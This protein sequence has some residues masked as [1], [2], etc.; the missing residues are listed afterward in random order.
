LF[1]H[2]HLVAFIHNEFVAENGSRGHCDGHRREA[3]MIHPSG[4]TGKHR[5]FLFF[6]DG[7]TN[8]DFDFCSDSV[9]PCWTGKEF[10]DSGLQYSFVT[11]EDAA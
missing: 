1:C 9:L 10:I 2:C 7:S 4:E 6:K 5:D 3:Q 8:F 11:V